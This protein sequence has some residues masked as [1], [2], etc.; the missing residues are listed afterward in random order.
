MIHL[1]LLG[2]IIYQFTPE[3]KKIII[4]GISWRFAVLAILNAAYVRFWAHGHY[5]VGACSPRGGRAWQ[6]TKA[7]SIRS[8][9]FCQFCRYGGLNLED[10]LL[11]YEY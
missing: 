3:G 9:P 1:L 11:T 8:R 10:A 5:V 7:R 6:L 4:D 2:T